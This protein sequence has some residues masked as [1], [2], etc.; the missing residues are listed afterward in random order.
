MKWNVRLGDAAREQLLSIKDIRIREQ[1]RKRIR[2]L[3]DDPEQQGKSLG[4]DLSGYRSVRVVKAR[5]RIL[6]KIEEDE[7]VVLVVTIGI[8][9]EGSKKDAYALAKKLKKLG[10]LDRVT[11]LFFSSTGEVEKG[12]ETNEYEYPE[13]SEE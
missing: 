13:P 7:V 10:L 11:P 1:I 3:I 8:R 12:P 9:R 4:E 2:A 6:Y 5:Y